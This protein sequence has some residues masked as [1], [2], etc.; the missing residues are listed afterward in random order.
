MA[1][2]TSLGAEFARTLAAKDSS[3]I[4]DLIH[5]EIDVRGMTP[6]YFWEAKGADELMDILLGRWFEDD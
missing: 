6:N 2:M 4:R 3:R 5:P 1:S